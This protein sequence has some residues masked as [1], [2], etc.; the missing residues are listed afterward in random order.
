MDIDYTAIMAITAVIGSLVAIYQ[1]RV[2][3]MNTR[4]ITGVALLT[5]LYD[6]FYDDKMW[7]K[8]SKA[9]KFLL[10]KSDQTQFS[11]KDNPALDDILEFFEMIGLLMKRGA[12][13][14]TM[15]WNTFYYIF[16]GYYHGATKYMNAYRETKDD[17]TLWEHVYF[18]YEQLNKIENIKRPVTK[19]RE[20]LPSKRESLEN[21]WKNVLKEEA[22]L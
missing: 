9:S 14:P 5:D 12:L 20:L 18:L 7:K 21:E 1:I 13:D 11:E 16:F 19:R 3:N 15:V 22:E 6:R 8:R 2:E 17:Q 4:F 10:E